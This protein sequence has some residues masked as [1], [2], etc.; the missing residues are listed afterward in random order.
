MQ[1]GPL[2]SPDLWK[3]WIK[4]RLKKVID[5][6]RN[7]KP[8]ILIFYHSCGDA[9]QFIDGLIDCGVDI[10]NPVQPECMDFNAIHET[11]GN[12]LSFGEPL[13]NFNCCHSDRLWRSEMLT[14]IESKPAARK[15]A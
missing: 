13:E 11:Y 4:P 10:L 7:I 14:E 2:I 3:T 1:T 8:Y 12:Q 5:S 15:V 9:T 6:A